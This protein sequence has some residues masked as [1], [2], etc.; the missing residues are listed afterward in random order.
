MSKNIIGVDLGGTNI[1][2]G[3]VVEQK[4]ISLSKKSTPSQGT[5]QE[6]IDAL[7]D[8]CSKLLR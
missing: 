2:A 8:L 5:E 6:V 1:C 7:T 3:K 4:I